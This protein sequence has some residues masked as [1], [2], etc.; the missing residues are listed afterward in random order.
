MSSSDKP[1]AGEKKDNNSNSNHKPNS[2][3]SEKKKNNFRNRRRKNKNKQSNQEGSKNELLLESQQTQVQAKNLRVKPQE[4]KQKGKKEQKS[5]NFNE[6]K[7]SNNKK[8]TVK[9]EKRDK[10]EVA[11]PRIETE[12]GSV[13][14]AKIQKKRLKRQLQK[15]KK[16]KFLQAQREKAKIPRLPVFKL[17]IRN[18][19]PNLTEESFISKIQEK[20]EDFKKLITEYYYVKGY[21]PVNQFEPNVRSRCYLNFVDE[22]AM[23]LGGRTIKQM[24]FVNDNLKDD[25]YSTNDKKV[26][27]KKVVIDKEQGEGEEEKEIY[28]PIIEKSFYQAMPDFEKLGQLNVDKWH[29]FN[30]KLKDNS[31]YKKYL[32][33]IESQGKIP[34]PDNIFKKTKFKKIREQDKLKGDKNVKDNSLKNS[35][36]DENSKTKAEK[37]KEKKK[38]KR[39]ERRA[40]KKKEAK[41]NGAEDNNIKEPSKD[42]KS[43]ALKDNTTEK[44]QK[45]K[46]SRKFK[47]KVAPNDGNSN[48]VK[49]K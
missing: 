35:T 6:E 27:K 28:S 49:I 36:S 16:R 41:A 42:A 25:K 32:Q 33:I 15:E 39:K 2:T 44:K 23:M 31:S 30:G 22:N 47:K 5:G 17:T 29:F 4:H 40:K 10:T 1:V 9:N 24:T 7:S 20:N 43:D 19:P 46:K 38:R 37:E 18:L 21:Y 11:K 26:N 14:P 12:K 48:E 45:K 3:K 8:Q 13:L 34:F